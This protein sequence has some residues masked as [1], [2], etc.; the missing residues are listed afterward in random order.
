QQGQKKEIIQLQ[1]DMERLMQT[2][3]E[4]QR[5]VD[6]KNAVLKTLVEQSLDAINKLNTSLGVL[7][8]SIQDAQANSGSRI[9]TLT[10]QV[11]A[12]ADNLDE[13]KSRLGKINQQLGDTQSVLQSLDAKIAGGIPAQPP[14]GA[15]PGPPPSAD[16]LYSNALRDYTGGKYDLARQQFLD[17]LKFFPENDL[18]SNS[19]FYLGE[20]FY[21]QKQYA[22]AIGEYDKVLDNYSKSNKLAAAR[23]KKGMA[24]LELGQRASALR[25]LREVV[26]RHPAT[27]EERRARAKLREL[28]ASV[29]APKG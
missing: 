19:Q 11:Q 8:K 15:A 20:I 18:A 28:G 13:V 6:E 9:D 27:E 25:E 22:E 14:A 16:A 3:R 10:T 2:Q 7:Q 24:L 26:R 21:A 17:Y 5:T 29:P 23:L 1:A 12:L 4:L